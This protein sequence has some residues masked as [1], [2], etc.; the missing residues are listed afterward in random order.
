MGARPAAAAGRVCAGMPVCVCECVLERE[1][2]MRG[3]ASL[4]MLQILDQANGTCIQT[5][6]RLLFKGLLETHVLTV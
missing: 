6:W 1:L 3:H 4:A 5:K 2:H